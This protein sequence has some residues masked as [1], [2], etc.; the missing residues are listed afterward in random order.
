MGMKNIV[1]VGVTDRTVLVFIRDPDST[2]G[3]GKTG[4]LPANLTVSY[5]RVGTNNQVVVTDVT[6]SLSTLA[7]LTTVHTDWGMK[8]VSSTLAP[9]LYRLDL[10]DAVFAVNAWSAVVYVMMTA[11]SMVPSPMEFELVGY[12][13]LD[14]VRLG[15][16][17]LPSSA[18]NA[19]GGL[20][21]SAAGSLN[22]DLQAASVA[23]ILTNTG[24][25]ETK[26]DT[27]D[28]FVDTEMAA[29]LA[30]VDTEVAAI[31]TVTDQFVFGTANRVN[32]QVYGME[33]NV[34]TAAAA[35]TDL[36]A[37]LADALLDKSAGVETNRTVREALRLIL[38]IAV[39]KASGL[40]TTTAVYRDTNDSKNRVSATVD[41]NGNRSAV[42]LD[43]S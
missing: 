14:D 31:K 17:S 7:A 15:L 23:T 34:V 6:S 9:G 18:V 26:I 30:A 21:T 10:A 3:K 22:A 27:V 20:I 12:N 8:E 11:S 24:N 38:S 13:P 28:N 40:A 39:G 29:V 33:A 43:A 19:A 4:L 41:A 36:G 2:T 32:A 37:E 1:K 35:A 16:S 25:I 42:T 5:T